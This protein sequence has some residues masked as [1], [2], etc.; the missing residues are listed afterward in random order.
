MRLKR[1]EIR[2]Y[3][4]LKDVA[5]EPTPLAVFVGPNAAGK[6][7]LADALDFLGHTYRWDLESAVAQKGG[8]ENICYRDARRSKDPI[9]F[10]IVSD[11]TLGSLDL[12]ALSPQERVERGDGIFFLDHLF[13]FRAKSRGIQSPFAVESERIVVLS[14]E[15]SEEVFRASRTELDPDDRLRYGISDSVLMLKGLPFLAS[16]L[17]RIRVFQLNPRSCRELGVPT[18]NPDL[19]RFG[20][21][22]PAAFASLKKGHPQ[23]YAQVLEIVR[24]INPAVE[25]IDTDLTHTKTLALFVKEKGINRPWTSEDI[26]DGTI[27]TIALLVAVFDPRTS[28]VV[29]EEPENSVHPWAL[30]NLVEAFR[31]ASEK[32]QILLTTHSP[33]LIDQLKPEEVWVV[34][35]PGTETKI[36][37]L[38]SLDPSLEEAW[39]QGKFTLSEY[40]DSGAVPEAVPSAGL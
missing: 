32:K 25:D 8:Y 23:E 27:Q 40:L 26:S 22:L 20:G 30:R 18:P 19:D 35:K 14:P 13:E 39:G 24:R 7:N 3:K 15:L 21:N 37:P 2:N 17:R 31:V 10:R 4:S 6:T 33:I 16:E 34:R 5:I 38:L 12:F 29:I 11:L 9:R 36:D 1:L 28:L